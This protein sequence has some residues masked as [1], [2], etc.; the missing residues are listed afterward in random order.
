[1][2]GD[3]G[4]CRKVVE[5]AIVSGMAITHVLKERGSLYRSQFRRNRPNR[6]DIL[7][8][9]LLKLP[10]HY[11][12][13]SALVLHVTRLPWVWDVLFTRPLVC[14]ARSGRSNWNGTVGCA[15]SRGWAG[16]GRRCVSPGIYT[17]GTCRRSDIGSCGRDQKRL[18]ISAAM[19]GSL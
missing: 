18:S 8:R 9:V 11:R 10:A 4:P 5:G 12:Q 13:S 7:N 3:G 2:R 17:M 14:G 1:M 6:I 16:M 15:D 19:A